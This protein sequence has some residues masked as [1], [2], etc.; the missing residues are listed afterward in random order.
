M[1]VHQFRERSLVN[2]RKYKLLLPP[3]TMVV[4]QIEETAARV[5]ERPSIPVNQHKMSVATE[6]LKL[7]RNKPILDRKHTLS[8]YMN[9]GRDAI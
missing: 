4:P 3:M 7:K 6:L 2:E 8:Q 9:V 5:E 1:D